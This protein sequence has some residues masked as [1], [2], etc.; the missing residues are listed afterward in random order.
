MIN[1]FHVLECNASLGPQYL[2]N[3][4]SFVIFCVKDAGRRPI[5]ITVAYIL[6]LTIFVCGPD[7]TNMTKYKPYQNKMK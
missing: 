3:D 7:L 1:V 5:K 6:T 2:S 4:A